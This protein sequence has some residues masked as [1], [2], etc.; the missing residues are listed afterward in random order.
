MPGVQLK[1]ET[2]QIRVVLVSLVLGA[3]AAVSLAQSSLAQPQS[4]SQPPKSRRSQRVHMQEVQVASPDGK[5]KFTILPDAERLTFT[6]TMGN[7]V[8]IEPSPIAMKLDGYDLSSGVVFNNLERYSIDESYPDYL[9][10][11]LGTL[12]QIIFVFA[13][14]R[15]QRDKCR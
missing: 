9:I 5:I 1:A 6:V 10:G 11:G 12:V 15:V 7:T 2:M 14:I 4:Q 13:W 8:V 3:V